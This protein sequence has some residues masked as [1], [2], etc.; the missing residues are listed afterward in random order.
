M[1][2]NPSLPVALSIASS[3]SGGGAGIQAD[4]LTFAACGAFGTTAIA[5]LTAQNPEGVRACFPTTPDFLKAQIAQVLSYFDVQAIKI[6]MLFNEALIEATAE[7]L[8]GSNIPTVIDP[9]MIATSGA[10]LLEPQA[11]KTLEEKLFPLAT[12]ITPNLDEAQALLGTHPQNPAEMLTAAQTLA[13]RYRCAVLLKGGHLDSEQLTDIVAEPGG[14]SFELTT[15]RIPNI[16]T[17]GSGCTLSAAI[18]AH[19]ALGKTLPQAVKQAHQYL[20]ECLKQGLQI[21]EDTFIN[22]APQ[23]K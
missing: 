20:N 19:L 15:Q 7:A 18:A 8:K 13:T 1:P 16:N 5:A 23:R 14:E 11:Q 12:L 9:V 6:G 3:D 17:H 4:L 10:A 21:G 22:H 2:Q